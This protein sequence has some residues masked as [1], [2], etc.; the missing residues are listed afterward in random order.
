MSYIVATR[1]FHSRIAT[2]ASAN[3]VS[4]SYSV[5]LGNMTGENAVIMPIS[6]APRP[7]TSSAAVETERS[8]NGDGGVSQLPDTE[9]PMPEEKRNRP[10]G[11]FPSSF[12]LSSLSRVKL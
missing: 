7:S 2:Q 4:N 1:V 10:K 11:L 8:P 5:T 12:D 3:H 9:V 6:N